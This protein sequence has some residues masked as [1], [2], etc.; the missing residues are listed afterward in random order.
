MAPRSRVEHSTTEL[1]RSLHF[2]KSIAHG[3]VISVPMACDDVLNSKE[4]HDFLTHLVNK[5]GCS[6]QIGQYLEH[7][8]N[9]CIVI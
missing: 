2:L 8:I 5:Y 6:K 7:A 4:S 9:K 1:L 3:L